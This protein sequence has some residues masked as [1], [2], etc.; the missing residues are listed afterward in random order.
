MT[1]LYRKSIS[2]AFPSR[3]CSN[4]LKSEQYSFYHTKI[5]TVWITASSIGITNISLFGESLAD[6][7]ERFENE[8]IKTAAAELN[9]YLEGKR[10]SFSFPLDLKGTDFQRTVWNALLTIPYGET[11]SYGEIARQIGSPNAARAVGMANHTNPVLIAVPC[12]R[13]IG[14]DGSLTGYGS[15]LKL[16][17]YLLD[18]EREFL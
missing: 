9:E 15:G 16:K 13:V 17:Q 5:G 4:R 2:N 11:R 1:P 8:W 6:A 12:H 14:A 10:K 7:R 18:L 3:N